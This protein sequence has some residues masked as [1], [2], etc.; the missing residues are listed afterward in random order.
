MIFDPEKEI[1]FPPRKKYPH[2]LKRGIIAGAGFD[3]K[4]IRRAAPR[5][6]S[7]TTALLG[8]MVTLHLDT[9]G[10]FLAGGV[11]GAPQAVMILEEL[12]R[13][14]AQEIIFL[15]LGGSLT[16]E[17]EPGRLV[18]PETGLST[19]GTSAHYPAPLLPDPELRRRLLALA[20]QVAGGCIWSTDGIFRETVGLVDKQRRL[21][22]S[23]VDMETTAL[24]AA[25]AFR[26]VSLAAVIVISD[27]LDGDR[28]IIG[29]NLPEFHS[30]LNQAAEMAW[31]TLSGDHINDQGQ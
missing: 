12:I 25:A 11:L 30:S 26:Q 15:G 23:T 8:N 14:G 28:H 10:N 16:P 7:T 5:P 2:S 9:D 27:R 31:K 17:L 3:L 21:G 18:C 22:A 29:F 24:W 4:I 19:E 20:P 13:R 1:A 6:L